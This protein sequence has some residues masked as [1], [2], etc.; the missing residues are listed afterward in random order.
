MG[1]RVIRQSLPKGPSPRFPRK[2]HILG[3]LPPPPQSLPSCSPV[4]APTPPGSHPCGQPK[5]APSRL[6]CKPREGSRLA[7]SLLSLAVRCQVIAP[8]ES[9]LPSQRSLHCSPGGGRR[10]S[11]AFLLAVLLLRPG[12]GLSR[13]LRSPAGQAAGGSVHSWPLLALPLPGPGHSWARRKADGET[14]AQA[15]HMPYARSNIQLPSVC[16]TH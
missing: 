7:S 10:T 8:V 4:S 12:A 16:L 15:R 6:A 5:A 11:A 2:A 14:E 9:Q 1:A 3:T 13:T